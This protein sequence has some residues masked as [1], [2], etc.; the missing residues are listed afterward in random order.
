MSLLLMSLLL[1]LGLT[2]GQ[3]PTKE[4]GRESE[5]QERVDWL[6]APAQPGQKS[7]V[8]PQSL[9][10]LAQPVVQPASGLLP[11]LR[12]PAGVYMRGVPPRN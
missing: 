10:P 8:V 5:E 4:L 7:S 6:M 11:L 9:V 12:D 3:G 2:L 1:V